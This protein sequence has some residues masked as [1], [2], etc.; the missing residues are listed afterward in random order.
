MR[1]TF[2][3]KAKTNDDVSDN[4]GKY[5][6]VEESIGDWLPLVA[7]TYNISE[8]I[9]DYVKLPVTILVSEIPNRNGM[10]FPTEELTRFLRY[11]QASNGELFLSNN[12]AYKTWVMCPVFKEHRSEDDTKAKGVVFDVS[13]EELPC[14]SN[15]GE[16]NLMKVV[17]LVGIDRTK[18]PILANKLEAGE[19]NTFSLGSFF[20]DANCSICGKS[21]NDNI[22]DDGNYVGCNHVRYSETE[23][24]V[25]KVYDINGKTELAYWKIKQFVGQEIS[26]VSDPAYYCASSDVGLL[27]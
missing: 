4:S 9:R 14:K 26:V 2:Q 7:K 10:A 27:Q 13:L 8:N 12:I 16:I 11:Q 5:V 24:W 3:V 17:A 6:A 20:N 22:D 23:P 1:Y 18:D 15:K 25:P 19:I 21:L